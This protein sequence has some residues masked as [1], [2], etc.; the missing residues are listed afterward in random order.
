MTHF[1]HLTL[2]P[3]SVLSRFF[4]LPGTPAPPVQA[5]R[6]HHRGGSRNFLRGG[7]GQEFLKGGG[8][9]GC[10]RERRKRK[11][12]SQSVYVQKKVFCRYK[13]GGRFVCAPPPQKKIHHCTIEIWNTQRYLVAFKC[14]HL[15]FTHIAPSTPPPPPTNLA[16]PHEGGIHINIRQ[17]FF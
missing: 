6:C 10:P 8:G 1:I 9:R 11:A 14:Q 3:Y 15:T 16:T 13:G 5:I 4:R 17:T 2:R 7:G 12:S